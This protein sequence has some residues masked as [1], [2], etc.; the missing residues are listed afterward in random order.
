MIQHMGTGTCRRLVGRLVLD[1]YEYRLSLYRCT[2]IYRLS[3]SLLLFLSLYVCVCVFVM[4][5]LFRHSFPSP[6]LLLKWLFFHPQRSCRVM[7]RDLQGV[8]IFTRAVACS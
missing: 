5:C 8:G 6:F 4:H 3:F 1:G 7:F 2:H